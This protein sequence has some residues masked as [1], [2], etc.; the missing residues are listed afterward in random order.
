MF[1]N[2]ERIIVSVEF[3]RR[4][5]SRP[6]IQRAREGQALLDSFGFRSMVV[7]D[8]AV[9]GVT[10]GRHLLGFGHNLGSSVTPTIELGLPFVLRHFLDGGIEGD[11]RSVLK[12]GLPLLV[13]PSWT[14]LLHNGIARAEGLLPCRTPD[15]MVYAPS[16][17]LRERWVT[18]RLTTLEQLR[19]RQILLSMDPLLSGLSSGGTFPFEDSLS[20]EVF[21]SLFRQLWGTAVGGCCSNEVE[22]DVDL[23]PVEDS[24]PVKDELIARELEILKDMLNTEVLDTTEVL[25]DIKEE[26][27]EEAEVSDHGAHSCGGDDSMTVSVTISSGPDTSSPPIEA[28]QWERDL[29]YRIGREEGSLLTDEDTVTS[30]ASE[31]TLCRGGG[32][33]W[34]DGLEEH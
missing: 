18:R 22:K 16:Y 5:A 7:A 13:A 27:L 34:D 17:K 4:G 3:P 26:I 15:I 33:F 10:D 25:A 24:V 2:R 21:T 9:G 14:V 31:A 29:D 23:V 28:S 8:S 12:A 32:A 6:A 19:L 11:F 20:P 1:K 30:V